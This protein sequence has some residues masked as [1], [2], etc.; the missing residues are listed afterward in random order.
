MKKPHICEVFS[1]KRRVVVTTLIT[2]LDLLR[3]ARVFF[4]SFLLFDSEAYGNHL[5][6]K[7]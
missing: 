7:R 6:H 5:R 2:L 4:K 1:D 3:T